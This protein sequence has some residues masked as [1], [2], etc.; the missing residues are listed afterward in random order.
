MK[1]VIKKASK[2]G[3]RLRLGLVGPAGSGKTWTALEVASRFAQRA[4]SRVLVIDT[5]RESSAKYADH[6]DFDLCPINDSYHPQHY[7]DALALGVANG[8]R[9]IV[10]DSLSH[11]WNGKD[12]A[13]ALV[14]NATRR[15]TSGNSYMAWRDVT[16]LHN[17]LVD[18]L[19]GVD[20]HLIVTLRAKTEYVIEEDERGKKVPRRIGTAPIQREGLDYEFDVVADMDRDNTATIGKTRC[21][22]LARKAIPLP[23][24][25]FAD[26]LWEW[27]T[28]TKPTL[29]VTDEPTTAPQA[30]TASAT[31]ATAAPAPAPAS[32]AN[33]AQQAPA[34]GSQ[35]P[36]KSYL[37]AVAAEKKRI[38]EPA[39]ARILQKHNVPSV[40]ALTTNE[41]RRAF[42]L[43]LKAA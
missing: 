34:G 27:V 26:T 33:T 36:P 42:Y 18:A 30:P 39:F 5:E 29:P 13:L 23:G 24:Q 25:S 2:A 38:G 3:A 7:V 10:V 37:T 4:G 28:V 31:T 35:A 9:V 14:D 40:D 17:A 11:A 22:P 8:Y 15:S 41:R 6:F 16:P 43:D 1:L 19:T 32:D 21:P 12:G 20:A